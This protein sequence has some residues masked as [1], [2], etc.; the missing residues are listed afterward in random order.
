MRLLS[1]NLENFRNIESAALA[2]CGRT[3]FLMGRNAQGKSNLLEAIGLVAAL[4]SFRTTDSRHFVRHQQSEA[5]LFYRI[6]E[7]SGLPP[8]E[9]LL[10]FQPSGLKSIEVD[11]VRCPTLA[12]F[13]GR[14]PVLVLA[15]DDISLV[16]GTPALRRRA[17]DLHYSI[18]QPGY[19]EL[20]RNYHRT[21]T[22]RN[23]AL[24]QRAVSAVLDACDREWAHT[25][26][27]LI[28]ARQALFPPFAEVYQ[29]THAALT[30]QPEEASLHFESNLREPLSMEKILE[31]LR[32]H[33]ERDLLLGSTQNGPHR[34]DFSFRLN[35]HPARRF[36]SEGQKRT[37]ALSLRLAQYTQMRAAGGK[38]PIV[39]A[40]DALG[41]LDH[42]RQERFWQ[43]L[44]Q[45]S[46][47]FASGT[48]P[49]PPPAGD[50]WEIFEVAAG[51][52]S[53]QS[54]VLPEND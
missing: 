10:R 42:R 52:F 32:K 24:R 47:V 13:V 20:L 54:L 38:S 17:L 22:Q 44:P 2:F 28:E 12:G 23:S 8:V 5:R 6:E 9:V 48:R 31:L 25:A 39:L 50:H 15:A 26:A 53:H 21:L 45:D 41:E 1:L 4:R 49:A 37:C 7:S 46:Q 34:D 43:A 27:A 30:D 18:A 33:R 11:G 3:S 40:D 35:G 19:L 14:F 16:D 36:A 29:S 51:T